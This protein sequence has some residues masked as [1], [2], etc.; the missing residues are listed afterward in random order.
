MTLLPFVFLL[1]FTE[2]SAQARSLVQTITLSNPKRPHI[3]LSGT[4]APAVL[5]CRL[6]SHVAIK[7]LRPSR[8]D[9]RQA[10]TGFTHGLRVSKR[11]HIQLSM[12]AFY[13]ISQKIGIY[14]L[15]I[16]QRQSY[17]QARQ[18]ARFMKSKQKKGGFKPQNTFFPVPFI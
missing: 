6:R 14:S 10:V 2:N 17:H 13:I 12:F 8:L 15:R 9:L 3:F 18:T 4:F 7:R 11:P 5:G 16:G 1:V